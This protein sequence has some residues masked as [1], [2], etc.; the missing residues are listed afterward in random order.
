ME[1][2]VKNAESVDESIE[3]KDPKTR[4]EAI[5]QLAYYKKKY[6]DIQAK[7]Q[8]VIDE[9]NKAEVANI[10]CDHGKKSIG[11]VFGISKPRTYMAGLITSLAFADK[12][13]T[14]SGQETEHLY[15]NLTKLELALLFVSLHHKHHRQHSL[16][17]LAARLGIG[18]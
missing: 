18:R 13:L 7:R 16:E 2:E 3:N 1:E 8:Q 6:S 9:E 10:V 5:E 15:K 17:S 11:D 12:N 14:D 4:E